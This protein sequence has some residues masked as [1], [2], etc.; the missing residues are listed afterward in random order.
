MHKWNTTRLMNP[1]K[2][3]RQAERERYEERGGEREREMRRKRGE[4]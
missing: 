1:E 3:R 4:N 2:N